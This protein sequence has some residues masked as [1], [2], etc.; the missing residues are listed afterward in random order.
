MSQKRAFLLGAALVGALTAVAVLVVASELSSGVAPNVGP[1]R[2]EETTSRRVAF[3]DAIR[4]TPLDDVRTLVDAN[5]RLR[6]ELAA[7]RRRVDGLAAD[8]AEVR[9]V[10]VDASATAAATP[11]IRELAVTG[12]WD[13]SV[14]GRPPWRIELA[15]DGTV[16]TGAG[17]MSGTWSRSGASLVLRW[18]SAGAPGGGEWVDSLVVASDGASFIGTNQRGSVIRGAR[19]RPQ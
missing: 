14:D 3:D 9:R 11:R 6:I 5:E 8:L 12:A 4:E 2:S 15:D 16:R 1:S 13:E 10:A 7:T 17:D 19:P 18:P